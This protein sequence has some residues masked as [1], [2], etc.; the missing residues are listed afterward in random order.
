M[1]S[2]HQCLP[3]E[4]HLDALYSIFWYLKKAKHRRIIFDATTIDT[5]ESLFDDASKAECK[6]F[7]EYAVEPIPANI[8]SPR[9]LEVNHFLC[10]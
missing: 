4:G 9:G 2:Q 3:L 1:L 7:Y 10:R 8:P 6:N 5:D